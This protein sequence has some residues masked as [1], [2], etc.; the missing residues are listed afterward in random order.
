MTVPI[1]SNRNDYTGNGSVSV[2]SYNYKIFAA[3]DLLVTVRD[4]SN[5]QTTLVNNV[6]YVVSGVGQLNGGSIA[7]TS[8]GQ[9]WIQ[10]GN[11]KTGYKL[12]I[13]RV[14][15]LT[16][17]SDIRNQGSYFPETIEDT[18]DHLVM[19][20]QQVQD[21]LDRCIKASETDFTTALILPNSASRVNGFLSFD[22]NGLPIISSG[23][24]SV[25]V[26]TFMTAVVQA[27]TAAAAKTLLGFTGNNGIVGTT[28][29]DSLVVT[30]SKLAA[31]ALSA[32][33]TGLTKMADGFLSADAGGRAKMAD[34]FLTK[35][36]LA[37]DARDLT[38][39]AKTSNFTLT[40]E[41]MATGDTSGGAFTFTLPAATRLKPLLLRKTDTSL[42][43]LTFQR[44]GSD[45]III[46][47][48]NTTSSTLNTPDETVLLIPDGTSK[49][50]IVNREYPRTPVAYTP[51]FQNLGTVTNINVYSWREGPF[52]CGTATFQVGT[53]GAGVASMTIGFNGTS[54]NVNI[55]STINANGSVLGKGASNTGAAATYFGDL[56]VL[57]PSA[58][59]TTM[60]FGITNSTQN[61]K[62]PVAGTTLC[63]NNSTLSVNFRVAI[64]GW[65]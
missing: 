8:T 58:G 57:A 1:S 17:N 40:T 42:T 49:W 32:D 11:L 63:N 21:A 15:P 20:N 19:L 48:A 45:N 6:D 4:T 52:L 31:G 51:T 29:L 39:T 46:N 65:N 59:S 28:D 9:S 14:R 33:S 35:A 44:G 50:F 38:I 25:P 3:T 24:S 41:D 64:S 12:T 53:V 2:Y 43:A 18:F 37:A 26:S 56:T 61:A 10:S 47:G 34:G 54:A 7:L 27:A 30:T 23:T 62:T 22:S 5:I 55:N 16:Q 13:R 60:E 36:K